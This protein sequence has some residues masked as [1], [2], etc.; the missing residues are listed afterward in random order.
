MWL[1]GAIVHTGTTL[2]FPVAEALLGNSDLNG[3]LDV[4]DN[5]AHVLR[6]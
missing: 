4:W 1:N 3:D 2:I 5:V 6:F